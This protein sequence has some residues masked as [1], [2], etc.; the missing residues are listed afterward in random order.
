M[1]FGQPL[2]FWALA[3]LPVL[4]I[5]F[6]VHEGKR[7]VLIRKLVAA[8]LQE[9]LVG[10]VSPW[11]RGLKFSLGIL[12]LACVILSLT[13]PRLGFT[14]ETSK[15]KGRDVLVAIDVSKSMLA[16]D[17][18]PNRLTK[19]KFAAQDLISQLGGDRVGLVAFAGTAFLQA[20]LTSDFSAIMASL[21]EMDSEIIPQGGSNFAEAI[22]VAN[23]AFGKGEGDSRALIIFS[24]GE[25][26]DADG[27]KQAEK[28]KDVVKIFA[29][30]VGTPDGSL[31]PLPGAGGGTEFVRD[32]GGQYVKSRLDEGRL[33][34]IAELTGGFYVHLQTGPSDMKTIVSDG[35]SKM[36]EQEIDAKLSRQPIE[37][38][39]WPL[40]AGLVLL[41][42]SMLVGERKRIAVPKAV[43]KA[44]V[45]GALLLAVPGLQARNSGLDAYDRQDYAGAQEKFQQ[46]LKR[47]PNSEA[48]QFNLGSTAYK[49][50][51]YTGALEAFGKA[52]RSA[53]PSLQAKAQYNL[54]NTLFQLGGKE[55]E[56]DK[57]IAT[58]TEALDHY[59]ETLKLEPANENAKHNHEVVSKLI[60][61]LKKPQD[62][63][64]QQQNQQDKNDQQ[65]DQEKQDQ[66]QKNDQSKE[67]QG[68][69]DQQKKDQEQKS[70]GEKKDQDG[71]Q[72]QGDK[73]EQQQ[74][75][76][77]QKDQEK[78]GKED[79]SKQQ[80]AS[81]D[82]KPGQEKGEQGEKEK[83]DQG[84]DG[85]E[86]DKGEK[87]EPSQ[88]EASPMRQG[89]LKSNPSNM[90][91]EQQAK[92]QAEAQAAEEAQAAVEGKM[93]ENQAKQLLESLRS[94]DERVRLLDPKQR[95][96]R[97][98]PLRDW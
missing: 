3:I 64:Q 51:D 75:K 10:T 47:Q 96:N 62:Q 85:K 34:K 22:K 41:G 59:Q 86:G 67:G 35:L 26:L 57:K 89:E 46:Q 82:E 20:P 77:E 69:D 1:N 54:G 39:Q 50:Q 55:K 37:R 68:K 97:N 7:K 73:S 30:G 44:A 71:K 70:D 13:Q 29:V 36:N 48:L 8:R 61:E 21:N 76:S 80:E 43:K 38:Y 2:W 31:I 92:E 25:E 65:K 5:L 88:E 52:L 87:P 42:L 24:D 98:I 32:S 28:V 9:R 63:Q 14:W 66:Q 84:Q 49:Q 74:K 58:W 83:A 18:A 95:K 56:K 27:L 91:P 11:K 15:R 40:T 4:V 81:N 53:D 60:E 23:E 79:P 6:L 16:N 90:S 93:T 12:G 45:V 78:N 72:E 94:E 19:A 33:R 17:V